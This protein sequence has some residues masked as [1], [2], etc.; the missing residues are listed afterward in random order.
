MQDI[1]PKDSKFMEFRGKLNALERTYAITEE[2][3]L[4]AKAEF[5]K[6]LMEENEGQR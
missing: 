3:T 5:I 6:E 1:T 4:R 2:F